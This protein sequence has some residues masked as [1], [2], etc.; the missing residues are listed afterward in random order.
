MTSR[1]LV[2]RLETFQVGLV[3]RHTRSCVV[4]TGRAAVLVE[5]NHDK[6]APNRARE[7]N[8]PEASAIINLG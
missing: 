7:A 4:F 2:A 8:G 5:A 6:L 1:Q 3:S